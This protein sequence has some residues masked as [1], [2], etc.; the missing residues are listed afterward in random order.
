[1]DFFRL[2]HGGRYSFEFNFDCSQLWTFVGSNLSS[3]IY[4]RG[5]QFNMALSLY[6]KLSKSV[7]SM[8]KII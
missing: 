8:L 7:A 4:R 5:K 6:E 2:C 3:N 1:M